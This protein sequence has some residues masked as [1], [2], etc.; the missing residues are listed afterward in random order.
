MY[1]FTYC[2]FLFCMWVN[3]FP[4]PFGSPYVHS[5]KPMMNNK[6][7]T[8]EASSYTELISFSSHY[9]SPTVTADKMQFSSMIQ[10][11]LCTLRNHWVIGSDNDG[12][13]DLVLRY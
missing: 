10:Q 12:E 11:R 7:Y 3:P 13:S 8:H 9:Q 1:F 4:L 2:L 5:Y 6:F